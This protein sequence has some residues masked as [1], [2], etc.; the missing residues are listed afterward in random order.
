MMPDRPFRILEEELNKHGR[1]LWA[2]LL[3]NIVPALQMIE[4]GQ[5]KTIMA[6]SDATVLK[7]LQASRMNEYEFG[8]SQIGQSIVANHISREFSQTASSIPAANGSSILLTKEYLAALGI[9]G[10]IKAGNIAVV[11]IQNPIVT[12]HQLTSL[13]NFHPPAPAP[14]PVCI[15]SVVQP[16]CK[17]VSK[18]KK[19]AKRRPEIKVSNPQLA[20]NDIVKQIANEWNA[21]SEQDKLPFNQL[22]EIDKQRYAIQMAEYNLAIPK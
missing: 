4:S 8:A 22:A 14:A 5:V 10:M 3:N 21:L 6:P 7:L 11:L 19:K 13:S 15:P 9:S 18:R 2:R 17:D 1:L 16:V 20:F 12:E